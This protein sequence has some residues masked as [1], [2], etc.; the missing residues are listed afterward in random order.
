MDVHNRFHLEGKVVRT[1]TDNGCNFMKAFIQL[2]EEATLLPDLPSPVAIPPSKQELTELTE[3]LGIAVGSEEDM[4][5]QNTTIDEILDDEVF[6]EGVLPPHMRG[7]MQSL[8]LVASV[9]VN[10]ALADS[11]FRSMC[12]KTTVKV[13]GL[14]NAQN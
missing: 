4:S 5:Y 10:K 8:N 1:M 9:D 7:A 14:W 3:E 11:N 2:S 13:Q 12:R 6:A